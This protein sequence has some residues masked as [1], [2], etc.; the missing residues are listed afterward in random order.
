MKI[1]RNIYDL[2]GKAI[3]DITEQKAICEGKEED[4]GCGKFELKED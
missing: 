1:C 3:C 4:C 2:G